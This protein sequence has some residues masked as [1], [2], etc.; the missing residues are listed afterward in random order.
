MK[1]GDKVFAGAIPELYDTHL[2]PVIFADYAA[3]LAQQIAALE[4]MAVLE[5]AAGTGVVTRALAPR[6]PVRAS[7]VV[8]DL[9]QPMLDYAAAQQ[10][11]APR[12][13]WR[14]ADATD[15]PFE[16]SVFD[17]VCS[18][19]GVMFLPDK[20]KGYRE[21]RRTLRPGGRLVF[22]TW[23][24]IEVN[25]FAH[26]VTE[27]VSA[28][29]PEDPPVFFSR[30]PHGYHDVVMIEEELRRAGFGSVEI[31]T[32]LK[33]SRAE[34]PHGLAV[35]FCQGTPLRNELEARDATRLEEITERVAEDIARRF[36]SG[37]VTGKMQAHV[38]MAT[39]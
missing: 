1:S 3:D 32:V 19:F 20:D 37:P 36:G 11:E 39:G 33:E 16:K 10:G 13:Q 17:V 29:F 15:L 38:V 31:T 7:Y 18:Q 35:A 4:P 24:R 28:L 34:D 14:Q 26:C 21:A 27:T 22:N 5:T 12:I 23:D 9:N 8:T 6:L 2:V 25:D 30:T